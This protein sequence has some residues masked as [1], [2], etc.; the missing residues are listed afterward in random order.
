MKSQSGRTSRC[1]KPALVKVVTSSKFIKYQ[2]V[3]SPL[4][5]ASGSGAERPVCV[6][7]SILTWAW[8][9]SRQSPVRR[10]LQMVHSVAKQDT[11]ENCSSV[12]DGLMLE[13]LSGVMGWLH[14]LF[15]IDLRIQGP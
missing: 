8:K 13:D 10:V 9:G 3:Y 5:C 4:L 6:I 7:E 11:A 14:W 12:T 1:F 2:F 15:C